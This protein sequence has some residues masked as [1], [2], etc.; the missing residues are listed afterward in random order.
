MAKLLPY[1]FGKLPTYA[2]NA[3]LGLE[4][5]QD[6]VKDARFAVLGPPPSR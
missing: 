1:Q 6:G 2:I 3:A 4:L 5:E